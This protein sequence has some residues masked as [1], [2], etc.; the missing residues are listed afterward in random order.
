MTRVLVLGS[1]YIAGHVGTRLARL[2]HGVVLGSRR[3]PATPETR[4]L[5][6]LPTDVADRR[7]VREL[8]DAI[9]PDAVV[10]AHGPS[11]ITWCEAEPDRTAAVHADGARHVVDALAGRAARCVLI[12]TDN[13]FPGRADSCSESDP[14]EPANAYGR[15]KL[16]AERTFL[17]APDALVLRV[18]LVYGWDRTGLRPNFFTTCAERL[19]VGEPVA[20]PDAHW[21]TPVLI[22]D[23]AAWTTALLDAPHTGV[24]HLGGPRR[25]SRLTWARHIAETYGVDPAL[26][27]AV[28]QGDTAYAC[29]PRN[30]CLHSERAAHLPELRGLEPLD[31]FEADTALITGR[32][33]ATTTTTT[34][35][36]P[37]AT[38]IATG[39]DQS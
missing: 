31:V 38:A 6:W 9:R 8:V 37:A 34:T 21:N 35:G 1:G 28:P 3:R 10:A 36:T 22:D 32:V 2:G 15:A 25:L 4:G 19:R 30:A 14:T 24:L 17:A 13:V 16:A 20:V 11:D 12:S 18:S 7:H 5:R 33:T 29:R 26:V 23:V 39:K 27:S